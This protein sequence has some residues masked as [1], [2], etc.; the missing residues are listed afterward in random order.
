MIDLTGL[1][2]AD[3]I[4]RGL[5]DLESGID[6][7][8]ALV[9]SVATRRLGELGIHVLA[10]VAEPELELYRRLEKRVE[11]PYY[12][13]NAVLAELDSFLAALEARIGRERPAVAAPRA[14][15][16]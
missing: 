4:S 5:T 3:R 10:R 2:A 13:Y 8:E 14:P 9:V 11:D 12:R 15:W 6:S 1:P 16:S 7:E